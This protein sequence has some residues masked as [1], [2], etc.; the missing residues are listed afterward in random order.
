V[1]IRVGNPPNVVSGQA[2]LVHVYNNTLVDCGASGANAS[3]AFILAGAN[4][5]PDVHNNLIFQATG[6]PYYT[7]SDQAPSGVHAQWSNN[8]WFGAGPAPVGD[9]NAVS[10]DPAL[11]SSAGVFDVHVASGSPAIGAG[12]NLG[13]TSLDFDGFVRPRTW[14]IGAY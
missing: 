14:N 3:G 9:T 12:V 13:F 4:W 5:T 1:N 8:L 2:I 10:A 11:V 7:A 6:F